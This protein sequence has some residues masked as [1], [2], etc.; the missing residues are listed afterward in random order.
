[1]LLAAGRSLRFGSPKQLADVHG[2]PMLTHALN[3][4]LGLGSHVSATVVLGANADQLEPL[5][6]GTSVK[7][8]FNKDHEQ[9]VAS[10]IRAGLSVMPPDTNAVLIALADQVAV[11]SEDL[12]RL[13]D[14]WEERPDCIVAAR[15]ADAIGAPAIFPSSLFAELAALEGDRGAK[16]LLMRHAERVV[17]ISM[18]AAALDVDTPGALDAYHSNAAKLECDNPEPSR[19]PCEN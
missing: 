19:G 1:M 15:Y 13:V 9:G 10:S 2:R 17:A 11:T 4:I 8:V 14:G 5:V 18:P 12:R 3:T 7:P 6:H 16:V